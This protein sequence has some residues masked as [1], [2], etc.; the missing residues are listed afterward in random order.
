MNNISLVLS[1]TVSGYVNFF[2]SQEAK[3]IQKDDLI[4]F[5]IRRFMRLSISEKQYSI[6]FSPLYIAESLYVG[7]LDTVNR[8]GLYV[9]SL[10]IPR[11]KKIVSV[12][13]PN[14]DTAVYDLLNAVYQRF[15]EKCFIGEMLNPNL[16]VLMQ[17]YYSDILDEYTLR[18]DAGQEKV[19]MNVDLKQINFKIGYVQ[20]QETDIT[21]Y[22]ANPCRKSYEGYAH[23]AF[24][25]NVSPN[26]TEPPEEERLYTVMVT[27][28]NETRQSV[29][30]N[31]KI[32]HVEPGIG[33][34]PINEDYTYQEILDNKAENS[35]KAE[36]RDSTILLTYNFPE[37]ELEIKISVKE[38]GREIPF[39]EIPLRYKTESSTTP[40]SIYSNPWTFKGKE[41]AEVTVEDANKKYIFSPEIIDLTRLSNGADLCL[42]A[43]K[44]EDQV[45]A[46]MQNGG[47]P[48]TQTG[49]VPQQ[50]EQNTPGI[51]THGTQMSTAFGATTGLRA[52]NNTFNPEP[53]KKKGLFNR[54]WFLLTLLL[55]VIAGIVLIILHP[56]SKDD[57]ID[58]SPED[59]ETS[60]IEYFP[61]KIDI[62]FI[63]KDKKNKP[64]DEKPSVKEMPFFVLYNGDVITHNISYEG[65]HIIVIDSMTLSQIKDIAI[66]LLAG[67][68]TKTEGNKTIEFS[69]NTQNL[70]KIEFDSNHIAK[71][72][73]NVSVTDK[74]N[75]NQPRSP[76][77]L[78][79]MKEEGFET[80]PN[81]GL[82]IKS[83]NDTC[84]T[85]MYND[86]EKIS[87]LKRF[88]RNKYRNWNNKNE[89]KV[90][91]FK[92]MW[93]DY[94][95]NNK[96]IAKNKSKDYFIQTKEYTTEKGYDKN[97]EDLFSEKFVNN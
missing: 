20:A 3:S 32:I 29:K 13:N 10:I 30:L 21:A 80:F 23:V 77:K 91:T 78:T 63:V 58:N 45:F 83:L 89:Y 97:Y 49:A 28:T 9:F 4:D 94:Y 54:W 17:D 42:T 84:T 11:G 19:N 87:G 60:E 73:V 16:V 15:L 38:N 65:N 72:D 55:I 79:L 39:G 33:E 68:Y 85:A 86:P 88:I 27:N 6:A 53:P 59:P 64:S 92:E 36:V 8:P 37:E 76:Q 18:D 5:D 66:N 25:A 67:N 90:K 82:V 61:A 96:E 41:I 47:M 22:L 35:I 50:G 51:Q 1:G 26:I 52:T 74:N 40:I 56:W 81:T 70:T 43:V 75:T 69:W 95:N 62:N 7:C 46:P 48:T 34:K 31:E 71:I 57:A 93:S 24:G 2:V 44:R 14:S 12:S